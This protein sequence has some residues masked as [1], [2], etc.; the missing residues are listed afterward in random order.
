MFCIRAYLPT[1]HTWAGATTK[2]VQILRPFE[3]KKG[4]LVHPKIAFPV[5]FSE[6]IKVELPH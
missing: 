6:V 2:K 1:I 4:M 5:H 3:L